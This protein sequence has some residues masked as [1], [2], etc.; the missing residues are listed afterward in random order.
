[1]D[2]PRSFTPC[3]A[4]ALLWEHPQSSCASLSAIFTVIGATLPTPGIG[5]TRPGN[6]RTERNSPKQIN[7]LNLPPKIWQKRFSNTIARDSSSLGVNHFFNKSDLIDLLSFLPGLPLIEVETNGT[8]LPNP[9]LAHR[10]SQFNVSPKLSNSGIKESLRLNSDALY[11]FAT[12]DKTAFKFVVC[13]EID[14]AEIQALQT[15]FHIPARKIFL[16]PE[17][18]DAETLKS[19]SLWLADCCR[20]QGYHFSPRLHVL[21]W[22][23]E[24]AK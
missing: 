11:F 20:D 13:N 22:G 6:I 17:G 24:R 21:L 19:R 14:L 9:E 2:L 15:K 3:K 23:N 1:M 4:K 8:Q 18:R 10:V 16:M 5:K 7:F 12:S